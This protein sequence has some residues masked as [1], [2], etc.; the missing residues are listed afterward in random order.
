MDGNANG[1][2]DGI[3]FLLLLLRYSQAVIEFYQEFL[4][5]LIEYLE[6]L[7]EENERLE[8]ELLRNRAQG[9]N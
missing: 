4:R 5:Y 7:I 3:L 8:A 2:R 6:D 9:S 1:Q